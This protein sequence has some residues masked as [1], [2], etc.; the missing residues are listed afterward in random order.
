M[1]AYADGADLLSAYSAYR[2][3]ASE[4]AAKSIKKENQILKQN[5]ASAAKAPV[6][7][8]SGGGSTNQKKEDPFLKGFDS[9]NW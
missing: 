5:A 1:R 4:K 9:D 8:V 7:G 2:V 6:K 3:Q